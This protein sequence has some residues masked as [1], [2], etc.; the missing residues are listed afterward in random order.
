MFARERLSRVESGGMGRPSGNLA[1][2]PARSGVSSQRIVVTEVTE[3]GVVGGSL[4][5]VLE[6]FTHLDRRRFE[7]TLVLLEPKPIV[8]DLEAQGIAVRIL[9]PL[10]R[11]A[12]LPQGSWPSRVR[13][14]VA[15]LSRVV[16]PRVR[17]LVQ[18]FRHE[19][20]ALVYCA[21]GV[22]PSLPVVVAAAL[23]RIPVI[24]HF[25]GFSHVGPEARFMSRWIDTAVCMTDEI[26]E[27]VRAKGVR[28]RRCLTI[29]D[30]IDVAPYV[31]GKGA[32]VRREFGIP[33]DAPVVGIVGHIQEWKG[34]VLAV[35]AVARARRQFPALR[36]L[37]VGGVHRRGADYGEQLRRRIAARIRRT[38]S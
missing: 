22:A 14:R 7:P 19:R 2:V 8:A 26:G 4:T 12:P 5:G 33:A 21:N 16:A 38:L 6:F 36:C 25:K 11:Q 13:A 29:F 3:G 23:C 9:P 20:P 28:A 30:G 18:L 32:A 24:C 37:V 31:P 27:H 17:A 1:H 34:Q 10:A 35:E 15:G